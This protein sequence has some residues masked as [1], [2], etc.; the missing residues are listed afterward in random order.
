M[1]PKPTEDKQ[2]VTFKEFIPG[3]FKKYINN[4]GQICA[5]PTHIMTQKAESLAH[6]VHL[7]K[8]KEKS[9]AG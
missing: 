7:R 3:K 4:T 5:D 6:L 8:I 9:Y 1:K 2:Y